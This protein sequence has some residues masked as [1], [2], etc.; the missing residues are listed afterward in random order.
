MTDTIAYRPT[1]LCCR[2]LPGTATYCHGAGWLLPPI[3]PKELVAHPC[4]MIVCLLL[5][6]LYQD[7]SG[8]DAASFTVAAELDHKGAEMFYLGHYDEAAHYQ[9]QAL[10][11]WDEVSLTRSVDLFAPHFNLAQIYLAQRKLSAAEGEARLARQFTTPASHSRISMLFAQ[12]HF[13]TGHYAEA[14]QEIRAVLPNL[15]VLDLATALNDLG[16]VRAALGNLGEARRLMENSLAIRKQ[17]DATVGPDHGR[18]LGNLALVC[19]R[20][21]DLS[22]AVSLYGQA[23]SVLEATL[24]LDHAH[25]AMAL[26]EYS[27][28]LRK[29]G[30]KSEAKT[31]ERRAK[32]IL[33]AA[34]QLSGVQTVDV[35][36]L[37]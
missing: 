37:R 10:R 7:S 11:I 17:A 26:A 4:R 8:P 14:E 21:G 20:Q 22:A 30:R 23:I 25:L 34:P 29:S 16:M 13:Q 33:A 6:L 31:V 36:S 32:T 27:Q 1:A 35:R 24:G 2:M 28:V 12:I 9:R 5:W 18:M 19:F 15:E 3:E